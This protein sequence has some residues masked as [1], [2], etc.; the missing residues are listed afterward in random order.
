VTETKSLTRGQWLVLAAAFLGWMFDGIEIGMT[1][2][3]ARPAL[4]DLLKITDD[5]LVGAWI[6]VL[7]A[8]FLLGAAIGGISFGWLGDKI[9]RVRGMVACMLMFS[10]FMGACYFVVAPWQFGLCLFLASLGMGGEWSLAVALVMEVW[11]ERHRS[12]LAGII[13][14]AANF[15]FL[16]V[17]LV[18]LTWQVRVDDW[19]WMMLVGASPAVLALLVAFFVPESERWKAA[20]KQGGRSPIVEI[21]RPGLRKR[22]L[23]AM[24][25]SAIPLIGT[26]AA[27]SGYL[28]TWAEQMQEAQ[29]GKKMLPPES[30]AQFEA[31]HTPKERTKLLNTALSPDHWSKVRSEAAHAKALVQTFLAIGA[32]IGCILASILGGIFGRR[33]VYFMLCLLS[34]LSCGYMFHFVSVYDARFVVIGLFVGGIT[35]AFYGWLPLYLPELF[36]TRIRATGQGLSFNIGRVVAAGG[37]LCM[38]QFVGLFGNDYGRAMSVIT[39]I[40]ILG[41]ILI[42]FA[43]ETKGKPLP[44]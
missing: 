28:P 35:A 14:A 38:G 37:T 2:L 17:S 8:C 27:V 24:A 23:L 42:W 32:I 39:F 31:A 15:G 30:I 25:F 5:K 19:R 10:L 20:A 33:P 40:Y 6:S 22:T 16:F 36:P 11:P 12:K 21:F 41:L 7:M 29:V 9:G 26:W 4:Q 34:F 13:G 43:P 44:D 1:P 18:A 3:V